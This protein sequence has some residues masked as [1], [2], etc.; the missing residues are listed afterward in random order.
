MEEA[1]EREAALEVDRREGGPHHGQRM[2]GGRGLI[3]WSIASRLTAEKGAQRF[4]NGQPSEDCLPLRKSIAFFRSTD[5]RLQPSGPSARGRVTMCKAGEAQTGLKIQIG[6]TPGGRQVSP[7]MS[8][9]EFV[10][11]TEER[12]NKVAEAISM[13]VDPFFSRLS[14]LE[15]KPSE[16]TI[17][18]GVNAGGEAGVPFVTKGTVGANFKIALKWDWGKVK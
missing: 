15:V 8:T 13:A 1:A 7:E 17:E 2:L 12:L 6:G 11:G 5:G 16:C 18:F 10:N 14:Q 4:R 9:E 3:L